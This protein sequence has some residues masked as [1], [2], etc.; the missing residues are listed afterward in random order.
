MT[1]ADVAALTVG[2]DQPA[3]VDLDLAALADEPE[4][5]SIPEEAAQL[6]E[7]CFIFEHNVVQYR[8]RLGDNVILWSGNHVG[9]RAAVGDNCFV[10]SHVVISGYCAIGEN[11]FLGVN[12]AVGD[13]VKVAR[14]C[15][16][17]AGAVVVAD[18][19]EGKVYTGD[20]DGPARVGSLRLFK[21]REAA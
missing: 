6:F 8:A 4:L 2:T 19:A 17:G 10:S 14:D 7:N 1:F 20:R 15:V 5:N 3:A 11:C 18:T 9:H 16:L 13:R 21:V 12:S